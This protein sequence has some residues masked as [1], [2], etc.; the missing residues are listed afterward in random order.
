MS[1]KTLHETLADLGWTSFRDI[2][3]RKSGRVVRCNRGHELG[4][5]TAAETWSEL[6]ARGLVEGRPGEWER[7]FHCACTLE[8]LYGEVA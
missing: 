3:A 7:R 2:T 1:A 8:S 4:I 6:L 5:L